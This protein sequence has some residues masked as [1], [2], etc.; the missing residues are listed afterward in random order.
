MIPQPKYDI[1]QTVWWGKIAHSTTTMECP[2]CLGTRRWKAITPAGTEVAAE[3]GRCGSWTSR[4]LPSL[5]RTHWKPSA[6]RLTIGS[7]RIDTSH[8]SPVEYMCRETG[9]GSGQIYREPDLFTDETMALATAQFKADLENAK[10]AEK[11][12]IVYATKVGQLRLVDATLED[13]RKQVWS[14]WYRAR[15]LKEDMERIVEDWDKFSKDDLKGDIESAIN[16]D[17]DHR[18]AHPVDDLLTKLE[19][20]ACRVWENPEYMAAADELKA[21]IL[22]T[23][24]PATP[25]K[26]PEPA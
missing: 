11:P 12:E 24:V 4:D 9:V 1:G 21:A 2:D 19:A 13:A 6:Q 25:A 15:E 26:E 18:K 23:T 20:F 17:R 7:V 3:C 10:V 8:D 16:W 22:K 5:S 14:S